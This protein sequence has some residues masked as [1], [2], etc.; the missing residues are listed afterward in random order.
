MSPISLYL[1]QSSLKLRSY[2]P[3]CLLDISIYIVKHVQSWT[4]H[5]PSISVLHC[6]SSPVS[7][8]TTCA[9]PGPENPLWLFSFSCPVLCLLNVSW[10]C[11]SSPLSV[12]RCNLL[13]V[14]PISSLSPYKSLLHTRTRVIFLQ[15]KYDFIT[16]CFVWNSII[17]SPL[18]C[19]TEK[20]VCSLWV[21]HSGGLFLCSPRTEKFYIFRECVPMRVC[22]C[23]HM[24]AHT[25]THA[26]TQRNMQQR[27]KQ[28]FR[29]SKGYKIYA[30]VSLK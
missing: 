2:L 19:V 13:N 17:D 24:C 29:F 23:V 27:P 10:I 7:G 22:V 21:T 1:V 6:V 30:I 15:C 26:H 20:A 28:N 25:H 8:T 18:F 4:H 3:G 14:L 5:L 11:L 16:L 12:P 9:G